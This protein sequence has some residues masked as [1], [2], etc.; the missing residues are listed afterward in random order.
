MTMNY[1][2]TLPSPP[3]NPEFENYPPLFK[4]RVDAKFQRGI[5][6]GQDNDKR[7]ADAL[8]A[9]RASLRLKS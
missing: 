9:F 1:E 4:S 6:V 3:G 8:Q 2:D 7:A 5:R